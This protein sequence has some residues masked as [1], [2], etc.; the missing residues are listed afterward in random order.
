MRPIDVDALG[1]GLCNPDAFM[2]R[3]YAAGWNGVVRLL[4][5]APTI[6]PESL[7]PHGEWTYIEDD[8]C[9][10]VAVDCSQCGAEFF[11]EDIR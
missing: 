3:A 9:D 11:G 4:Q 1:V 5:S 10:T 7:R 8:L 6:D 2:D